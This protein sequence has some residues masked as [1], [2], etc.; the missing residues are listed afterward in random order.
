[1]A[2]VAGLYVAASALVLQDSLTTESSHASVSQVSGSAA[3]VALLILAAFGV[4]RR[5]GARG[6]RT[7]STP[8][9]SGD[10]RPARGL[11]GERRVPS[12]RTTFVLAVLAALVYS[13]ATTWTVVAVTV[14]VL[15]LGGMLIRHV[16]GSPHWNGPHIVALA[17]AALVVRAGL[18]FTY[19]PVIGEVSAL[20]KYG[21]NTVLLVAIVV[22]SVL[23]FRSSARAQVLHD[24]DA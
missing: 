11:G 19:F 14:V 1:L 13:A 4:A 24:L 16:A 15:V 3:V 18:A 2:V 8:H 12:P 10:P 21:H 17:A 23:A 5:P 7:D 9:V 20:P 6:S 22:I